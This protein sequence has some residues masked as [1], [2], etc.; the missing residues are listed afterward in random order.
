[1][2]G[3]LWHILGDTLP[4]IIIQVEAVAALAVAVLDLVSNKTNY[5]LMK[6]LKINNIREEGII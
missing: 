2:L 1:M 4:H 6:I 3:H 5:K